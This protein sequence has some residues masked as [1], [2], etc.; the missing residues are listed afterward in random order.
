MSDCSQL[1]AAHPEKSP[2][3]LTVPP[4]LGGFPIVYCRPCESCYSAGMDV[5]TITL[6]LI[7]WSTAPNSRAE[8][9]DAATKILST[10][11]NNTSPSTNFHDILQSRY[12]IA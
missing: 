9:S 2:G 7:L 5:T 3:V 12:C 8:D 10:Y 6:N 4:L 1:K 11:R